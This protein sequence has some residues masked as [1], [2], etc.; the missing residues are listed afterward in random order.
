VLLHLSDDVLTITNGRPTTQSIRLKGKGFTQIAARRLDD[1]TAL[2]AIGRQDG[3]VELHRLLS[4]R[5]AP[6]L[7]PLWSHRAH[8]GMVTDVC[9]SGMFV[10][11]GGMDRTIC[12]FTLRDGWAAG[13]PVRLHRTLECAGMRFDGAEGPKERAM[14]QAL[15]DSDGSR[16]GNIPVSRNVPTPAEVFGKRRRPPASS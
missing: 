9:V 10:L 16:A 11:S 8:A 7:E 12:L 3:G 4:L 15:L 5:T 13:E 6:K 14:L 2:M 1:D